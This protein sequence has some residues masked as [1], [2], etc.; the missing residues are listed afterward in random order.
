MVVLRVGTEPAS[1]WEDTLDGVG[2][3]VADP[4]VTADA[5]EALQGADCVAVDARAPD[6]VDRVRRAHR[7]DRTVQTV[8]VATPAERPR[9][10]RAILF[11]P[12]LDEVWIVAPAELN[13][14]LVERAGGV[15]RKRRGYGATRGRLQR[16]MA[17]LEPQ[18]ARRAVISD[19]YLAALLEAAPDPILSIDADG[20]VLSWNPAAER[21]LGLQRAE[22]VGSPVGEVLVTAGDEP[23]P[24]LEPAT[25]SGE[26][27]SEL[28]LRRKDGEV[29]VA[30][31]IA[32]PVE[33]AG[34]RVRAVIIHDL[35]EERLAQEALEAQAAELE[36]QAAELQEQ[37]AELEMANDELNQRTHEL[38]QAASARSRFYSAMSHELRTPINAILGYQDLILAGIHGPL[39]EPLRNGLER[40]QRATR[41]L[42]ELVNDVLDLAKIE[43]GRID[44]QV[45]S[46]R[47]PQ[48]IDELLD[49][50]QSMAN[51]HAA[52]LHV[53]GEGVHAIE[54]DPRRV[55]Q[56]LL[57]LLS[58]AIKYGKGGRVEVRWKSLPDG[59]LQLEVADQGP[60]IAPEDLDRI[61]EEF[62]Q[63]HPET[64]GGTGLGL[65]ISRR[66]A[67]LLGG[68]LH[69]TSAPGRGSTF[70]LTLPAATR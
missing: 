17:A 36:A 14:A 11:A 62:T 57:N 35:T 38:E 61:F 45:E 23:L 69:V 6:A 22:A 29:V 59:G 67:H 26:L 8:V 1:E 58:N 7:A 20:T 65:A 52:T 40:A 5:R 19:A 48:L 32:M 53:R 63:L 47:F 49:T 66:L 16:D 27:R 42:V 21:V 30:E 50:V 2:I 18:S 44:L 15:T 70:R 56:I 34:D 60:G 46:T 41:H 33:A 12:G 39:P 64:G 31:L 37:A 24:H 68:T 28:R 9:I 13:A 25:G 55:R 51:Q 54:S 10:E 43:A 4:S 3:R